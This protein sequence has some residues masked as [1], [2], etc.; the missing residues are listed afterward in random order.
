MSFLW[1]VF[2]LSCVVIASALTR[3]YAVST[4]EIPVFCG[5]SS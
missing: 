3:G 5:S 2:G 1:A 4:S